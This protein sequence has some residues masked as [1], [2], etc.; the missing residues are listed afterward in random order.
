MTPDTYTPA[1]VTGLVSAIVSSFRAAGALEDGSYTLEQVSERT[2][3]AVTS[4]IKDCR[5]GRLPHVRYGKTLGMTPTQVAHLLEK[6][7][8]AA[9]ETASPS[10]DMAAAIEASR[11]RAARRTPRRAA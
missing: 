8:V 7:T 11:G 5:A 6:C 4:L 3:F 1:Q 10:D 2:G 9:G